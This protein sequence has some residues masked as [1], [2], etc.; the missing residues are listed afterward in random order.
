MHGGPVV[1]VWN[2]RPEGDGVTGLGEATSVE[3]LLMGVDVAVRDAVGDSLQNGRSVSGAPRAWRR[4]T[5]CWWPGCVERSPRGRRWEWAL[6][7]RAGTAGAGR[8]SRR[9]TLVREEPSER[10][11]GLELVGKDDAARGVEDAVDMGD[12]GTDCRVCR[13]TACRVCRGTDC[14]AWCAGLRMS[15]A[16]GQ[17][18]GVAGDE[19][20]NWRDSQDL[21][22]G[23][24]GLVRGT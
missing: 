11:Q 10:G 7:A 5:A 12:R 14:R 3:V 22:V 9:E 24:T 16:G 17:P 23:A 15:L 6:R 21:V 4:G 13:G 8:R 1:G 20:L 19:L 2:G 18:V